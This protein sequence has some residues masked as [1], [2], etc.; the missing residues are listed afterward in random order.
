MD[1]TRLLARL[2]AMLVWAVI[3]GSFARRK[4]RNPWGW[5]L[6][7]AFSWLIALVVLA[8]FPY[9]CPQCGGSVSNEDAKRQA[10][11]TCGAW[12]PTRIRK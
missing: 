6:L 1:E 8:F 12:K 2:L 10:C 4:N 5:G 7:G 9:L 3:V 11:P